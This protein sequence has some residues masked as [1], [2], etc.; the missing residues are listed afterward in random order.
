MLN[1]LEFPGLADCRDR[2]LRHALPM[3]VCEHVLSRSGCC[4]WCSPKRWRASTRCTVLKG[5]QF[6]SAVLLFY[7][8]SSIHRR[9]RSSI[10]HSA[11]RDFRIERCRRLVSVRRMQEL[12][13]AVMPATSASFAAVQ[14]WASA[15]LVSALRSS[16]LLAMPR[17]P[18]E[19]ERWLSDIVSCHK[20]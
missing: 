14:P 7:M 2:Q 5:V 12:G 15:R 18:V 4:V 6:L 19:I 16:K 17:W 11:R 3:D 8:V 13:E 1:E 20:K 9:P 10:F